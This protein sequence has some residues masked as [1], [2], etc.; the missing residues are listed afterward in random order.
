MKKRIIAALTA[1]VMVV[2][3]IPSS[4]LAAD[5]VT[6]VVKEIY[7]VTN[8]ATAVV[9]ADITVEY[10]QDTVTKLDNALAHYNALSTPNQKKVTNI[11]NLYAA[12]FA[13]QTYCKN[14]DAYKTAVNGLLGKMNED[15]SALETAIETAAGTSGLSAVSV[16]APYIDALGNV[17]ASTFK[18]AK[19]YGGTITLKSIVTPYDGADAGFAPLVLNNETVKTVQFAKML[20]NEKGEFYNVDRAKEDALVKVVFGAAPSSDMDRNAGFET[21]LGAI[22]TAGEF[23]DLTK[24][25]ILAGSE[26]GVAALK[27]VYGEDMLPGG[28]T[29]A[30]DGKFADGTA[31]ANMIPTLATPAIAKAFNEAVNT[32][33]PVLKVKKTIDDANSAIVEPLDADGKPDATANYTT[34]AASNNV[35]ANVNA[36][37]L[38]KVKKAYT[39]A[40]AVYENNKKDSVYKNYMDSELDKSIKALY[41]AKTAPGTISGTIATVERAIAYKDII[42]KL[43]AKIDNKEK[44]TLADKIEFNKINTSDD[45]YKYIDALLS[46]ID[47]VVADH[48]ISTI[49]TGKLTTPMGEIT[50]EA[51]D[52]AKSYASKV[53]AALEAVPTHDTVLDDLEGA[54]TKVKAAI[55]VL[56][57]YMAAMK[58]VGATDSK[59]VNKYVNITGIA[60]AAGITTTKDEY[61]I[62]SNVPE[63]LIVNFVNA[64]EV[65]DNNDGV[66]TGDSLYK[67]ATA[68]LALAAAG[69]EVIDNTT[70]GA[71]KTLIDTYDKAYNKMNAT[72][73]AH[74]DKNEKNKDNLATIAKLRNTVV[75]YENIEKSVAVI[76]K[77]IEDQFRNLAVKADGITIDYAANKVKLDAIDKIL[78][79]E[80]VK[81]VFENLHKELA[82]GLYYTFDLDDTPSD[83]KYYVYI[84]RYNDAKA[85]YNMYINGVS[86]KDVIAKI[87]AL[88]PLSKDAK[89]ADIDVAIAAYTA[90]KDAFDALNAADKSY[91][92]NQ[93]KLV[94]YKTAIDNALVRELGAE[95]VGLNTVGTELTSTQITKTKSLV[96]NLAKYE[97][98][99]GVSLYDKA[100]GDGDNMFP[101]FQVKYD[102]AADEAYKAIGLLATADVDQ[103]NKEITAVYKTIVAGSDVV[104]DGNKKIDTYAEADSVL[105]AIAAYNGLSDLAKDMLTA[106]KAGLAG[107]LVK[108]DQYKLDALVASEKAAKAFFLSNAT[109]T[110]IADQDATGEYIKPAVE[111]KD[112]LGNVISADEYVVEYFDNLEAGVA[113][114][115][116]TAKTNSKYYGSVEA[117]FKIVADVTAVV[118][119]GLQVVDTDN[120]ILKISVDKVEGIE[121]LTYKFFVKKLGADK[122]IASKEKT[123]NFVTF[124]GLAK[125]AKYEVKAVT[126]LNGEASDEARLK[127][128]VYTNRVG[129]RAAAM[130]KPSIKNVTIKN[131]V[132]KVTVNKVK[133]NNVKYALGYKKAGAK[134][135]K[136][137]APNAKTVKTLKNLKKGVKY[138]FTIRYQYTSEVSGTVV[139]NNAWAKYVTK[140]AK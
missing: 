89:Y 54:T 104:N 52:V 61:L 47:A 1:L 118:P 99:L 58:A 83:A 128:A 109:I 63:S 82:S 22:V 69:A 3:M 56:N 10:N 121:G 36:V 119:T 20:K 9:D 111:V 71:T 23:A 12:M 129:N 60:A 29:T 37:N 120:G 106:K 5:P 2:T 123:E 27:A 93:S 137:F 55:D 8:S 21:A 13:V 134:D 101:G 19:Q 68:K 97:K 32:A 92:T 138:T 116:V 87:D 132:A 130:Y 81:Y 7:K 114:V 25:N 90:T 14:I 72:L 131:R 75:R 98:V 135:F 108:I 125:N 70:Y 140:V 6:E 48:D 86:A 76:D 50:A 105:K 53:K 16:D 94:A 44:L 107:G 102:A 18:G 103:A 80:N 77:M 26:T 139:K 49:Y 100:G 64:A 66:I 117:T 42:K 91:V 43:E 65:I 28:E 46:D 78:A 59:V 40:L 67:D 113:K 96:A 30:A 136:W 124:T 110:A 115:V 126:M 38:E 57:E 84:N 127:G 88:A 15:S 39:D 17:D 95:M 33:T 34:P 45:A 24:E 62:A 133:Y 85:E 122:W 73:K 79:D 112:A 74:F 11:S 31:Y 51:T 4:A 41:D 35:A